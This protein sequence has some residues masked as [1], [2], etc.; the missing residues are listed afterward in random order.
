MTKEE[1]LT[2]LDIGTTRTCAVVSRV[3]K[4]GSIEI[5]GF[6]SSPTSGGLRKGVIINL[7]NTVRAIEE[8][9]EK[10]E[11]MA[12]VKVKESIANVGGIY[13]KGINS[14]GSRK[15]TR[16]NKEIA[17]GDVKSVMDASC[18]L[19]I[20]LDQEIIFISP[21]EYIVDGHDGIKEPPVGILGENID[22]KVH[23]LMGAI[24]SMQNIVKS[25][26]LAGLRVKNIIPGIFGSRLAVLDEEEVENG[27]VLI[28]IGGG[29]TDIAIFVKGALIH[30]HIL[31]LGGEQI[32]GD[33]AIGLRSSQ[34]V[35]ERIK[36][37]YGCAYSLVPQE[38]EFE[39]PGLG[40]RASNFFSVMM[41]NE[42][43]QA[44]IEEI[45]ELV[46]AEVKKTGYEDL[47][48][49]GAVLS[50][51]VANTRGISE[52]AG[53]I[54]KLPIKIGLPKN[55]KTGEILGELNNPEWAVATGLLRYSDIKGFSFFAKST[56]SERLKR[57][58]KNFF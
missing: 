43:I 48:S 58:F 34:E 3:D 13:L 18:A 12:D 23:L 51:G 47:L 17:K 55:I 6:G 36:K 11:E 41:L 8:A 7:E 57:W 56:F 40:G 39:V 38:G 30:T 5:L 52:L 9:V 37:E 2:G 44:R 22:V 53:E 49:A 24:T 42:I 33:I 31:G 32:T 21:Q 19:T 10:A 25:I 14:S 16:G 35:A 20:P 15:I 1:I 26:N 4:E 50:G 28:D 54:L 45:F 46:K 27:V 29:T